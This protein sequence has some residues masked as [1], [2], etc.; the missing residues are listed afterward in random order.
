MV[1]SG[2]STY[3]TTAP[4][5]T[6]Y[7]ASSA[8]SGTTPAPIII[9]SNF[10]TNVGASGTVMI[11]LTGN[12]G[13]NPQ[14]I[15]D[16]AQ[17]VAPAT[18]SAEKPLLVYPTI[19]TGQVTITGSNADLANAAIIV[20]DE[21]GRSVYRMYNRGATTT[22]V[23]LNLGNLGNGL[24]FVRVATVSKLKVQKIILLK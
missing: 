15:K 21:S 6:T 11:Y 10:K 12:C 23:N 13:E 1:N 14:S 9:D 17:A 5:T 18:F 19:T 2:S 20:T 3:L 7:L 24:Y 22:F 4:D 8:P 16:S